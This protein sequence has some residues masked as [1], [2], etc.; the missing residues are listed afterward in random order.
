MWLAMGRLGSKDRHIWKVHRHT[1]QL[2]GG[3]A[4]LEDAE[5]I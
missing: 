4:L 5:R 3:L 1:K 2:R